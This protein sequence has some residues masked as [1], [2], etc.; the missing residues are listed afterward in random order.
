[1]GCGETLHLST[2]DPSELIQCA[3]EECPDRQA[4]WTILSD[5]ETEH[6]VTFTGEGFTIRHP[7]KERLD[8][9]L[10]RCMLHRYLTVLGQRPVSRDGRYRAKPRGWAVS[11]VEGLYYFVSLDPEVPASNA[12]TSV[13]SRWSRSNK[14]AGSVGTSVP[15]EQEKP[16]LR[17]LI[18]QIRQAAINSRSPFGFE[19]LALIA[20]AS[21]NGSIDHPSVS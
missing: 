5:A 4:A 13:G 17:S 20:R 3:A 16:D 12:P 1:M 6:I 14:L 2:E 19:I 18:K 11:D 9:R 15:A 8:D 10:M 21:P 7:L